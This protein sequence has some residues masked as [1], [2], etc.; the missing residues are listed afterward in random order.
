MVSPARRCCSANGE[1]VLS[2]RN[3]TKVNAFWDGGEL[4]SENT[5]SLA[6]LSLAGMRPTNINILD[7]VPAD[8]LARL[9][10]AP[11]VGGPL[12]SPVVAVTPSMRD[13]T[14]L[15]IISIP[16]VAGGGEDAGGGGE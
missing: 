9:A 8:V 12:P 15:D 14:I 1:S 3:G 13:L 5:R 10:E 16:S 11:L 2:S 6:T 7:S 4:I